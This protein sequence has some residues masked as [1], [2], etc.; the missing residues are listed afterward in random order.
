MIRFGLRVV[1]QREL[2]DVTQE[3]LAERLGVTPRYIQLLEAGRANIPLE[4]LFELARV[5]GTDPAAFF[6][7]PSPE[8][9][10]RAGRPAKPI[11]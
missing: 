11:S 5:L 8:T 2:A 3:R 1:E 7:P 4:R 9:K 10:R 6:S